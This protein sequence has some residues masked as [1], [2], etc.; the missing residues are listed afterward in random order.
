M[1]KLLYTVPQFYVLTF[2]QLL[3]ADWTVHF[4]GKFQPDKY[5]DDIYIKY[6]FQFPLQC[7]NGLVTMI[8]HVTTRW[9]ANSQS[10]STHFTPDVKPWHPLDSRNGVTEKRLSLLKSTASHY[11]TWATP[12]HIL[13]YSYMPL[14][15]SRETSLRHMSVFTF[16]AGSSASS[17]QNVICGAFGLCCCKWLK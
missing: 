7:T 14:G 5:P 13:L 12:I 16:L 17:V 3:R 2:Y 15:T 8:W 10:G 1:V 6:Y 11:I 9:E 4:A